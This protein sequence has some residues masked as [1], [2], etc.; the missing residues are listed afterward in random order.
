MASQM[1]LLIE[2]VFFSPYK[3]KQYEGNLCTQNANQIID[4]VVPD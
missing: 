2:D 3:G 1:L 4:L